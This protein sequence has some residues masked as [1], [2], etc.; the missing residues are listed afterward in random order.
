M[1]CLT[2]RIQCF[3]TEGLDNYN[4]ESDTYNNLYA[5]KSYYYINVQGQDGKRMPLMTEPT[6]AAT[7]TVNNFN[8]SQY[9]EV[10]LINIGRLKRRWFGEDFD[11]TSEQSFAFNFPG[12]NT[13]VPVKLRVIAGGICSVPT[14]FKVSANNTEVGNMTIP[15]LGKFDAARAD[16]LVNNN[17]TASE[18]IVIKLSYN[19]AGVPSS[20]AYLD[21]IQLRCERALKGYGKQ[22]RFQYN[23]SATGIGIAEYQIS[24]AS[25]IN[26]IWDI[27]DIYNVTR[28]N[29]NTASNI[30]FK[31]NLGELRKYITVAL[32]DL[33]TPLKEAQTRVFNQNLKG[34]IFKDA[35]GNFADIDYIIVAP[36]T[37]TPQA[38]RL[39][40]FHLLTSQCKSS[41]P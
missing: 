11:V 26:Q 41:K 12:I 23:A 33:Y 9:H 31:A 17:I 19:N 24:N 10:D 7:L 28:T 30:T 3:Y 16:S 15:K 38:E 8:D 14:T 37:F 18:N 35:Q 2:I 39:A 4:R 29:T 32:N 20:K 6:G 5:D 22:F 34:N 36:Y 27:T 21:L 1:A 40:N 13:A 25:G